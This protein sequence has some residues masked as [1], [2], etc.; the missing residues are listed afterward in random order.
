MNIINNTINPFYNELFNVT[1]SNVQNKFKFL[2]GY[3]T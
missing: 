3:F 1:L 2:K